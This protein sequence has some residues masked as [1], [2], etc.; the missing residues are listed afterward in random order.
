MNIFSLKIYL[1][2]A[3]RVLYYL[4]FTIDNFT[5]FHSKISYELT[6]KKK[7]DSHRH[8]YTYIEVNE[9]EI[10]LSICLR[11]MIYDF[12][13]H[14]TDRLDAVLTFIIKFQIYIIDR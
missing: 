2:F 1:F 14:H 8:Y 3:D 5:N 13:I 6:T 12:C 7:I 10:L 11:K 4:Y 9:I